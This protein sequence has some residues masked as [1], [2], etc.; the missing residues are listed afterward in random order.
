MCDAKCVPEHNVLVCDVDVG[1]GSNPFGEAPRWF[2]RG[3]RYVAACGV[4]L[5]V[6]ICSRGQYKEDIGVWEGFLHFVTCTAWR[7]KPARFQTS[8]CSFGRRAGTSLDTSL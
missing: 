4:E 8:D 2:T 7:E 6:F 1:V 5:I 3:L